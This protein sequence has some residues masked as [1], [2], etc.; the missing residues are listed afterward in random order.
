MAKRSAELLLALP[1]IK[2][3]KKLPILSQIADADPATM[4]LA[5]ALAEAH[6]LRRAG[7]RLSAV[8]DRIRE[9]VMDT[10]K[11]D[12]FRIGPVCVLN[13]WNEGR[14]SFDRALAIEVAGITPEQIEQSMKQGGGYWV[15]E[16]AEIEE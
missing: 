13:R 10:D 16:L 12:G 3:A 14:R 4:S 11:Q 1:E 5:N 15:T 2:P 7:D 8:K 6:A 9:L